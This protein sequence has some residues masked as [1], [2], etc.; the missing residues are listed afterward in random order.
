MQ[1]KKEQ[2]RNKVFDFFYFGN[3][4]LRRAFLCLAFSC[5]TV[6]PLKRNCAIQAIK[7]QKKLLLTF[8]ED[9]LIYLL[10]SFNKMALRIAGK[11][12]TYI[13]AYIRN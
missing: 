9:T 6:L 13:L 5:L 3:L 8:L 4:L 10:S 1:M 11:R 12:I 2:F 7:T